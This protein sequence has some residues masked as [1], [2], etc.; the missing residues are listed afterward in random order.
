MNSKWD[1]RWGNY[2]RYIINNGAMRICVVT[3]HVHTCKLDVFCCLW[4][5]TR[6]IPAGTRRNNNVFTTST[7]RRRRRVDVVKTLSLR[8]YFVMCPLAWP[9]NRIFSRLDLLHLPIATYLVSFNKHYIYAFT[10]NRK[11][12]K[13]K[14]VFGSTQ[15]YPDL[16]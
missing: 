8:H 6:C 4:W 10:D 3:R 2:V 13:T 16:T 11:N 14:T 9:G 15:Y 1:I 12:L 7:R 5:N